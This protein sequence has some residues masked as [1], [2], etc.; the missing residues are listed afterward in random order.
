MAKDGVRRG[1]A[2]LLLIVTGVLIALV[3]EDQWSL[4]RDRVE[5]RGYLVRLQDELAANRDWLESEV[6]WATQACTSA[7]ATL[8]YA[9]NRM[10]CFDTRCPLPRMPLSSQRERPSTT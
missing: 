7:Q 3:V 2:E 1:L 8:E 4:Y 6:D 10:R 5:A 9:R